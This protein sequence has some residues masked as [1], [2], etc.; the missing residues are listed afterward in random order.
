MSKPALKI[1]G[2]GALLAQLK[3][4]GDELTQA[5]TLR[6]AARKA[7][8]PVLESAKAKV[9]KA[10]GNLHDSIHMGTA[11]P[12]SGDS[13]VAVGLV[14]TNK[15]KKG[16]ATS[17]NRD[18]PRDPYYWLFVEKGTAHHAAQPFVRPALDENAQVVV[19]AFAKEFEKG[20]KRAAKKKAKAGK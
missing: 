8:A 15:A 1:E 14:I 13:V 17:E 12:K 18:G 9:P 7:F 20:I 5:K 4:V 19:T 10:S 3:E 6:S 11:L 2:L 16:R